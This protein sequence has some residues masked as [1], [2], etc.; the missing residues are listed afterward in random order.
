MILNLYKIMKNY[1]AFLNTK[2]AKIFLI[3]LKTFYG[4]QR[5][6]THQRKKFKKLFL[7]FRSYL[8][9]LD[10]F[11]MTILWIRKFVSFNN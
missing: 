1:C 2:R 10:S 6:K 8:D 9:S 11:G 4:S 5:R 7:S 3:L